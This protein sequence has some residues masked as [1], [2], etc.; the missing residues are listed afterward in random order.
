MTDTKFVTGLP[1]AKDTLKF[2]KT[3]N[4][5]HIVVDDSKLSKRQISRNITNYIKSVKLLSKGN[6]KS[7]LNKV[8]VTLSN[9]PQDVEFLYTL[10][11]S[12]VSHD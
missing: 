5:L 4:R 9:C 1:T 7:T 6:S 8:V 3:F 10:M 11:Q 2:L 12:R